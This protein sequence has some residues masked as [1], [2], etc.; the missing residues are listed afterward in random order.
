MARILGIDHGN[1]R[2]GLAISDP[3]KIIARPLKTI[4]YLQQPDVFHSLQDIIQSKS[5]EE[6]I[7][8][9]PR[10]MDGRDT[11]QTKVVL[12]FA[13]KLKRQLHIPVKLIDERLS[14]VSAEKVLIQQNIKTGYNKEKIDETAAAIILQHY[15]ET[16]R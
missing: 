7:I 1:R 5:V 9:L 10:G 4:T 12:N 11:A 8:G 2:I 13:E 16:K 15:L 14:S 6:I 3:M